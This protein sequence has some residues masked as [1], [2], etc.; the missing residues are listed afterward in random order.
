MGPLLYCT[1]SSDYLRIILFGQ[2]ER[3][4]SHFYPKKI[5]NDRGAGRRDQTHV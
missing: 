2:I 5:K 1:V 3:N 4:Q